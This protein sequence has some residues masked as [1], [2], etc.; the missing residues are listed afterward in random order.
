MQKDDQ[1]QA[2]VI[3]RIFAAPREKVWNAWTDPEMIK[4]WWGPK[5][6]TVPHAEIDFKVGGK[7]L[8]AMRGAAGPGQPIRDF[9]SGGTYRE[10]VPMEKI[11]M[12]DSFTDEKGN[13]VPASHYGMTGEWSTELKVK[14][15]LEDQD[16]GTKMTLKH[17]G[18]PAGENR[19]G[20]REGW[21]QSFDK[22]AEILK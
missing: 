7:Y 12:T 22:L 3:E 16:G 18:I 9:W 5:N 17:V 20:A 19:D 11:V 13:I 14:I 8:F 2:L 4:K 1:G 15:V 10:I 6:F 21:G